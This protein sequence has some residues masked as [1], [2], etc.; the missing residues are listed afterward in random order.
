M[1]RP[2][3]PLISRR[4]VVDASLEIID[5][6]GIDALSIRRL[7]RALGV[8]GA[9]LYYHYSDKDAILDEVVMHVLGNVRLDAEPIGDWKD[10]FLRAEVEYRRALARHPN[11]APVVLDRRPRR[12]GV[13]VYEKGAEILHGIGIPEQH[14][15]GILDHLEALA[16]G[17]ALLAMPGRQ[18]QE[19]FEETLPESAH[20][21]RALTARTK[22]TDAEHFELAARI[23]LDG[24][25]HRFVTGRPATTD[26]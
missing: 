22:L 7:G 18:P 1:P 21:R 4:A 25:D 15:W 24:V 19:L 6:E 2:R 12:F 8:N 17:S 11:V 20:L 14:V 5:A 13:P 3:T 10:Y 23:F 26:A 9:S 16:I